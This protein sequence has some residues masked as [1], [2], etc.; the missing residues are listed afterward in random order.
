ML[1]TIC[2]PSLSTMDEDKRLMQPED[3]NISEEEDLVYIS[4]ERHPSGTSKITEIR[5]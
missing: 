5:R 4:D 3:G 1:S 2:S